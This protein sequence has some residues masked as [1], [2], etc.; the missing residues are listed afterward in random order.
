ML[1]TADSVVAGIGRNSEEMVAESC[2]GTE[3]AEMLKTLV[4]ILHEEAALVVGIGRCSE[5]VVESCRGEEAVELLMLVT[6]LHWE[7]LVVDVLEVTVE[8]IGKLGVKI[9]SSM[10]GESYSG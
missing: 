10:E 4:A 2:S 9:H 7:K 8:N 6:N 5:M 1:M 3:A